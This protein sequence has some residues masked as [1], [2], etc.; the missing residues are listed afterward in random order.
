MDDRR[1]AMAAVWDRA[2]VTYDQ[3]DVDFFSVVGRILA[4]DAGIRAGE[5]ALCGI[6]VLIPEIASGTDS[7]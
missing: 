1:A 3:V 7:Q 2:A 6:P 4:D 5:P